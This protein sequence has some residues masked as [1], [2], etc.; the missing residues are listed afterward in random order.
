MIKLL[1]FLAITTALSAIAFTQE[2]PGPLP[3]T[4]D[5]L[6][7]WYNKPA[8]FA[9]GYDEFRTR[10]RT[11]AGTALPIGN[12]PMG[13]LVKGGVAREFIPLNES[14]LWTEGLDPSGEYAKMGAYQALGSLT[15]DL[16]NQDSFSHY[17]RSLDLRDG[18]ARVSYTAQGIHYQREYLPATQT[19]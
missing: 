1:P 16:A 17:Q 15:I 18:I 9:T 4:P 11:L 3:S 6:T 13:A 19:T 8:E 12:G 2:P 10:S 14:S 7:L 5:R